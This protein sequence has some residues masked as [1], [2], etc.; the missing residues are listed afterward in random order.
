MPKPEIHLLYK[1]SLAIGLGHRKRCE[2]LVAEF[3]RAGFV[4]D[5]QEFDLFDL[6]SLNSNSVVILDFPEIADGVIDSIQKRARLVVLDYFGSA[7]PELSINVFEHFSQIPAGRRYSG[8]EF[9]LLRDEILARQPSSLRSDRVLVQ[10]GGGDLKG[11]SLE[12]AE[13]LAASGVE[14]DLVYGPLVSAIP[15]VKSDLIHVHVNPANLPDQ[16][17]QA[18]WA[19][20]NGGGALFECCYLNTPCW[21]MPQSDNEAR[22]AQY[23]CERHWALGYGDQL[24]SHDVK[25]MNLNV[26][27]SP[28]DGRGASKIVDIIKREII[29][30]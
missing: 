14:V 7:A 8:F 22:I 13:Y 2:S 30:G 24:Y 25:E 28:I 1:A 11:Q 27:R 12:V 20:T 6:A 23:F 15:N 10:L 9:I 5:L 26:V 16:M 29:G 17:A 4:V 3:R 19:V 21:I 18:K